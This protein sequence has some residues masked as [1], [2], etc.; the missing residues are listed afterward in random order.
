MAKR[1]NQRTLI[2]VTSPSGYV[3]LV[4]NVIGMFFGYLKLIHKE[5]TLCAIFKV[6]ITLGFGLKNT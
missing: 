2:V 6:V 5:Y 4:Y 1:G 3:H